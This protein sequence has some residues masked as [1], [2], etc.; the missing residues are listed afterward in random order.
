[1]ARL[2]VFVLLVSDYCSFVVLFRS[3]NGGNSPMQS[4]Q[5]LLV[6]AKKRVTTT[7]P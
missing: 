1:M 4:K 5:G 2:V 7:D 6:T 3:K